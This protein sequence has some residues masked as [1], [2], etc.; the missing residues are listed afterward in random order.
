MT[1]RHVPFEV[2]GGGEDGA[3]DCAG[4]LAAVDGVVV[5]ERLVAAVAAA[6][7]N[8]PP[9]ATCG[10]S[11]H[12]RLTPAAAFTLQH[13]PT[14]P[15]PALAVLKEGIGDSRMSRRTKYGSS[16]SN[17]ISFLQTVCVLRPFSGIPPSV[18][19]QSD[20][21]KSWTGLMTEMLGHPIRSLSSTRSH[22]LATSYSGV[23]KYP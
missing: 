22:K 17:N 9:A 8:T 21:P 19:L 20:V 10:Q 12:S 15:G 16:S 14:S 1:S 13:S 2:T 18:P 4:R 5:G 11:R 6:A 23:G 3:A 7:V